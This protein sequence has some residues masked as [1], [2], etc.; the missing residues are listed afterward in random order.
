VLSHILSKQ[1]S[2]QQGQGQ[3]SGHVKYWIRQDDVK[4]KEK[5]VEKNISATKCN[6]NQYDD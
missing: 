2:Q 1:Q 4:K 3:G 5:E 6:H